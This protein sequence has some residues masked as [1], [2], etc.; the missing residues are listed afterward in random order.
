M[1][2]EQKR[3]RRYFYIANLALLL[4]GLTINFIAF[5]LEASN[6]WQ[7]IFLNVGSD[8]IVVSILFFLGKFLIFDTRPDAEERLKSIEDL[9][10]TNSPNIENKLG[11]LE[12]TLASLGAATLIAALEALQTEG[13]ESTPQDDS[14]PR[15]GCIGS[16]IAGARAAS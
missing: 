3:K 9:L 10:K 5:G 4:I 8:I 16:N 15:G 13:L 6:N 11:D 7:G 14:G 1:T 2:V 12:K